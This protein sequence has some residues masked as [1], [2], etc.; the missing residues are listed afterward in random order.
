VQEDEFFDS[1]DQYPNHEGII[2]AARKIN[3]TLD[4]QNG[5]DDKP[6]LPGTDGS[7]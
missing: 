7:E 6:I 5:V 1:S 2:E 4:N 3:G